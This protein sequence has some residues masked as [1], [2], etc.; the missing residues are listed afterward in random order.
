MA[1][2]AGSGSSAPAASKRASQA[3]VALLVL[4]GVGLRLWQY[5]G[6]P[7]LFLDELALAES[8]VGRSWQALLAAPLAYSQTAPKGFLL[9]EKALVTLFGPGELA[10]RFW[11]FACGLAALL[12]FP[13]LAAE[14]IEGPALALAVGLFALSPA[15]VYYSSYLKPYATD[16]ACAVLFLLLVL[17]ARR[18]PLTWRRAL[19]LGAAGAL[20]VWFSQAAVLLLA[21]IGAALAASERL[22]LRRPGERAAAGRREDRRGPLLGLLALW[23]AGAAAASWIGWRA[24]TAASRAYLQSFWFNALLPWPPRPAAVADW[25]ANT[26]SA[27]FGRE[28]LDY[29]V[30]PLYVALAALGFAALWRQGGRRRDAALLL[31]G[32]AAVAF[33]AAVARQYPYKGR[34]ILFLLPSFLL[35]V[36]LGADLLARAGPR[37]SRARAVGGAVL[38]LAVAVPPLYVLATDLP[39]YRLEDTRPLLAWVQAR[40]LQGDAVYAY[41]GAGQAL[42]F[43]G[44]GYGLPRAGYVLGDCYAAAPRALLHELDA[45]RGKKRLWVLFSHA[46]RP[47][48]RPVMIHY[49]NRIG[50]RLAAAVVPAHKHATPTAVYAYLYDLSDPVRLATASAESFPIPRSAG[51]PDPRGS[52]LGPQSA[53]LMP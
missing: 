8:L 41:Y 38:L 7:S 14:L 3:A 6:N 4:A 15:L 40:R 22:A 51:A 46:A 37:P 20:A 5:L 30:T 9:V 21:G 10:L 2:L 53:K 32:P 23:G 39:V 28:G 42:Q 34:L 11:P 24:M 1:Y 18:Q 49:L 43:Y 44:P 17:R 52:C 33:A 13:L 27:P 16:L 19:G 36:A 29:R 45:F 12:L 25:L 31:A 35:V 47:I 26:L 48:D 50:T